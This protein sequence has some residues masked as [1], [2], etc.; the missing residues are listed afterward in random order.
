MKL[1]LM[2]ITVFSI[3]FA[4]APIFS[5][6]QNNSSDPYVS[7][8]SNTGTTVA[9]FLEIGV[10]ARAQAMGGAFTSV[11]DD[12]TA[13]YWNPAGISRLGG[14]ETTFNYSKWFVETQYAYAGVVAPL[15]NSAAV[16]INI[17]QF[18]FGEQPVR[19]VARPE[20]T[21]E[22]Y[23][24][25]DIALGLAFAVNLT[26]RFSFGFNFKYINQRIWH[27]SSHGFAMDL[28][29]LYDTPVDGLKL[30][31]TIQNFGTDMRLEGRDLRRAYDPD[32]LTYG[33]DAIN[34]NYETD[35]FSLPLKFRF[36]V[37][38]KLDL[39]QSQSVLLVTDVLH[40]LNNSESINLGC[41][42]VAFNAFQL[43]AGYESL[44]ER[45]SISGLS[46]GAGL[47]YKIQNSMQIIIDYGW[48][49]WGPFSSVDRFT[50]GLKF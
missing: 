24:A 11:A 40:P 41:E 28:G 39:T 10:G 22:I 6:G 46:L 45:D 13:M 5:Y 34:V 14:I 49:D 1:K 23:G 47:H 33:N 19:T 21:G 18:D 4:F 8:V 20:G 15:G 7:D 26:D 32:P 38:Y 9:T 2:L 30:G 16:G 17:T 35:Y 50:I 31:F 43:R 27:E 29:A 12:A 3:S 44:L 48:V 36:G 37:S 25:N 42:Y